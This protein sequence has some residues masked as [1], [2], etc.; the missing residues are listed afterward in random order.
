MTYDLRF[1][2]NSRNH[3]QRLDQDTKR[4]V[5]ARIEDL[6]SDPYDPRISEPLKGKP[7]TRKSRIGGWRIVFDVDRENRRIDV[8]AVQPRGQVYHRI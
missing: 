7:N 5:I 2:R 4:R 3:I 1:S 6:A 8:L